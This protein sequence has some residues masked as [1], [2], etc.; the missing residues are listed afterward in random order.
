M[1]NYS[2]TVKVVGRGAY[3]V[4][5]LCVDKEGSNFISKHIPVS[6]MTPT[7]RLSAMNEVIRNKL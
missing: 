4:V 5:Y 6:D 7:E 3:G 2:K 1:E